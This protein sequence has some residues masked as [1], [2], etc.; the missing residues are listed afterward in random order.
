MY[1]KNQKGVA[2]V[3]ALMITVIVGIIAL[4]LAGITAK[5]QRG[6]NSNYGRV[7]GANNAISG[8]NRAINF[9]AVL[10]RPDAIGQDERRALGLDNP[11][12]ISI[13]PTS[14]YINGSLSDVSEF[15]NGLKPLQDGAN[16]IS[17]K[18]PWYRVDDAWDK[19]CVNVNDASKNR[20]VVLNDGNTIYYVELMKRLPGPGNNSDI[21]EHYFRITAL[22]VDGVANSSSAAIY[23][24]VVRVSVSLL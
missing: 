16:V 17:S 11:N 20:C 1:I 6:D 23:Q 24:T 4:S 15:F 7:V 10:S 22:G 13:D 8:A 9:L 12:G 2:L 19:G 3:V 14:V 21:E 5:T 18:T